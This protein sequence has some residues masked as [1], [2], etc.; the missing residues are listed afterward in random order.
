LQVDPEIGP[1]GLPSQ[2]A[3]RATCGAKRIDWILISADLEFISY[4][5]LPEAV[6]DHHGVVAE[7]G[8]RP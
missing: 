7:I 4:K 3:A 6:S 8:M 5:V 2:S 1:K